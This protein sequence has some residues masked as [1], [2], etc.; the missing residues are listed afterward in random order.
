MSDDA[1]ATDVVNRY[2]AFLVA[3]RWRDA[4]DLLGRSS[5]TY[6]AGLA[7]FSSERAAYFQ[8]VDGKY[9]VAEPTTVTDW[10][11]YGET[12]AGADTARAVLIEVDYPALAGNN[13]GYEQFVVAPDAE[14][15]WRIWPVR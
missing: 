15:T 7:E 8:S 10:A 4:F 11:S 12:V 1:E 3:G 14:G 2:E 9:T 5:P 13:A 6:E